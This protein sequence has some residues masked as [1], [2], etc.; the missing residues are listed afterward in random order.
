MIGKLER[1]DWGAEGARGG[2]DLGEF[3]D[4]RWGTWVD[5]VNFWLVKSWGLERTPEN[6]R[7]RENIENERGLWLLKREKKEKGEIAETGLAADLYTSMRLCTTYV[8]TSSAS[9]SSGK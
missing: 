1:L 3:E 9:P 4:R 6:W 8:C 5:R 2:E 7:A